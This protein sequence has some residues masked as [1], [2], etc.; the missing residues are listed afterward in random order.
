M[1]SRRKKPPDAYIEDAASCCYIHGFFLVEALP[2]AC[3]A[4][5]AAMAQVVR[6]ILPGAS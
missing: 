1:I 6:G 4:V 2:G 5:S 3:I